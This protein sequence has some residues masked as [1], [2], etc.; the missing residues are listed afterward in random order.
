MK[1]INNKIIY[2][3]FSFSV[4]IFLTI[5]I[6]IIRI[7]QNIIIMIYKLRVIILCYLSWSVNEI[8]KALVYKSKLNNEVVDTLN[9]LKEFSHLGGL[10]QFYL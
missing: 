10:L 7:F 9:M 6:N 3:K 1:N 8:D 5:I 2:N 4:N